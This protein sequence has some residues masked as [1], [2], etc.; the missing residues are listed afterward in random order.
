MKKAFTTVGLFAML[1]ATLCLA[2]PTRAS[3]NETAKAMTYTGWISD[4]N[5]GAKGMSASHKACTTKC[6]KMGAKYVFV[7]S[8]TKAVDKISNQKAI[9]DADLGHEVSVTG[10]KTKTGMLH[11]DSVKEASMSM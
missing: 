8:K 2:V 7:D 4:S 9:T 1:F 5:C 6:V 3:G 10:Y 11:V